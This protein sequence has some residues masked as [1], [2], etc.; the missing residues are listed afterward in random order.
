MSRIV[1]AVGTQKLAPVLALVMVALLAPVTSGDAPLTPVP[2]IDTPAPSAAASASMPVDAPVHPSRPDIIVIYIDDVPPIDGRF[3]A[4][5]RAPN[6][7][8]YIIDNGLTFRHAVDEA[9]LCC[10]ARANLL[11]GL[12]T[13]NNHVTINDASLFDPSETI[14]TELQGAG[15]RT[16]WIGKYLNRYMSLRGALH[17][18]FEAGW[19]TF[20]PMSGGSY[21]YY[22]WHKGDQKYTRPA[23]HSMQLVQ[24]LAVADLRSAPADQP[25]FAVLSTYAGHY[26]NVPLP[27]NIGSPT[28][29][30]IPPWTSPRY[31]AG[32]TTDKPAWVQALARRRIGS[33]PA[34]GYPLVKVCQD[35]LGVDQLVAKVVQEQERRGRLADTLLVLASDNGYLY[36]DFGIVDKSVPWAT[37]VVLSMSWPDGMGTTKRTTNYPTSNIDFAPTFCE[38][39]GCDMGPYPDGQTHADGHSILAIMQGVAAEPRTSLLT[40]MLHGSTKLGMP[41]WTAVTTYKG[42]PLGQWHYIRYSGGAI[43]LYDLAADPWELDDV[44]DV[45]ANAEVITALDALRTAYLLEGRPPS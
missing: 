32:A 11:T 5:D 40:V 28:C 13:R 2:V 36:G 8:K 19:D 45:P 23:E 30:R 9:P 17:D 43:E 3:W 18:R 38:I 31:G 24:D 12:H 10:P 44:A 42:Y 41:S 14:A 25:L 6:I 27:A 1:A 35:M 29:A 16:S 15:Y 33:L 34:S 7:R 39:A 21:G 4:G 20:E 37:P 22:Y 26:P